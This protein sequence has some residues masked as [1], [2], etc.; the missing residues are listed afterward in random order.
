[1]ILT[2]A[3]TRGVADGLYAI[4]DSSDAVKLAQLWPT[5]DPEIEVPPEVG[6]VEGD[7]EDARREAIHKRLV[8]EWKNAHYQQRLLDA[9]F[10]N[11]LRSNPHVVELL[12]NGALSVEVDLEGKRAWF[13]CE[14]VSQLDRSLACVANHRRDDSWAG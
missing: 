4:L 7:M 5:Y 8:S 9:D 10:T 1:M 2:F 6:V 11:T 14:G 13:A 12:P 3:G